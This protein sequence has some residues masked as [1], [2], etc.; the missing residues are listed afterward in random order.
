[1][2]HPTQT[3]PLLSVT[4]MGGFSLRVGGRVVAALP[5]KARALLAYLA[6]QDGKPISREAMADLL[7]TD[8]GAEQARHSLRQTLLVLRRELKDAGEELFRAEDRNLMF[9][10]GAVETDVGRFRALAASA[11]RATLAE[12]AALYSGPLLQGFPGIAGDF[13]A[14]LERTRQDVIDSALDVLGRLA[15]ECLA[16]GDLPAAVIATERMLGLDPLREDLHRRLMEVYARSGRR[17][18]AIRQYTECT[19]LLR[20]ELEVSPSVETETLLQRIRSAELPALFPNLSF[21]PV[22]LAAVSAAAVGP[23]RI[24]ILP[25]RAIGPDPIPSY[26]AAGLI[27]D[28]V[29]ILA[30]LREPIVISSN[31]SQIF[32]D[33]A[34]D[35]RMVGRELDARYVV[36][37]AVRKAGSWLRISVE[38]ADAPSNAVLWAQSYDTK[39]MMLFDAQDNIARQ[40]VNTVIPRLHE[41]ELHRIRG[42]RPESMNAYDLVLQARDQVL[43]LENSA[44]E[45]AGRLIRRA[46]ALDPNYAAAYAL[47]AD[48]HALRVGQ[49]WSANPREDAI[50]SDQA[51]QAAIARDGLNARALAIH[52]H[53]KSFLNRDYETALKLFDRSLDAAPNDATGLMWSASTYAYV[54]DGEASVHR[55]ERALSLSPRDPFIFRFYSSLCLAHYTK[56]SYDEAIHW[57]QLALREA[58]GYTSNM[59]FTIAAMTAGKRTDEARALA[60]QLMKVQPDFHVQEVLDRHPYRDQERRLLI[61]RHLSEAGLPA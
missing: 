60:H 34:V 33:R 3:R 15:D 49:G 47:L 58:P 9:P 51:A 44:F 57:G 38:L 37:G 42:K 7:W 11:D 43:K 17:A 20:R 39:D 24:A 32:R 1:M 27:E 53:T 52:A 10:A 30:T 26:F 35:P 13:D 6:M 12:A 5:R 40:I 2:L 45:A 25:F 36:S 31:S 4:L 59:R 41:V 61:A 46:I 21:E 18:D 28:I 19:E 54:G 50:A 16:A 55:A 56:G 8:R 29:C 48:W 23:P 14:W 22:G